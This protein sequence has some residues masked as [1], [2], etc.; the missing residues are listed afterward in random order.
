MKNVLQVIYLDYKAYDEDNTIINETLPEREGMSAYELLELI[1]K[2]WQM[3]N[4]KGRKGFR[5]VCFMSE[6][7][8]KPFKLIVSAYYKN[9]IIQDFHIQ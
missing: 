6:E 2:H 8:K 7:I 1:S 5:V 4:E 9:G 3:V